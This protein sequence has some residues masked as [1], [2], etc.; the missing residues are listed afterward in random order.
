M[1]VPLLT[2]VA[3]LFS[4]AISSWIEI[5]KIKAQG[6]VDIERARQDMELK[7][8]TTQ[9][10]YDIE[11]VRGM[12]SSWKDEFLTITFTLILLANFTPVIQDY[13]LVGWEYLA[14]APEWFTYSYVG[15]V[16]ASFGSRWLI[17]N[18]FVKSITK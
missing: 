16:A 4:G 10:D 17:Q 11:A 12:A 7:R 9:E 15:M 3:S 2:N 14:K 18:R 1:N 5:K 6:A 8:I 13:V